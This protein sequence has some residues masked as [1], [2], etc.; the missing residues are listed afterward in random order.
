MSLTLGLEPRAVTLASGH[1][2]GVTVTVTNASD[3]VEQYEVLVLGLPEGVTAD[4]PAEALRLKPDASGTI[5]LTL[6]T[7]DE[8]LPPAGRAVAAVVVFSPH[9]PDV[10]RTSELAVTVEEVAGLTVSVQPEVITHRNPATT[11]ELTNTGNTPLDVTVSGRDPEDAVAVWVDRPAVR[12]AA[13]DRVQLAVQLSA[14]RPLSGQEVRRTVALRAQWD[15]QEATATVT[16]T[17]KPVVPGG[18]TRLLAAA[19]G[20]AVMAGT[21]LGSAFLVVRALASQ[22]PPGGETQTDETDAATEDTGGSTEGTEQPTDGSSGTASAT[23]TAAPPVV[24]EVD[25][26][27]PPTNANGTEL[28]VVTPGAFTGLAL[29]AVSDPDRD[30]CAVVTS[31]L[32]RILPVAGVSPGAVV[33]P[34]DQGDP[35]E[36]VCTDLPLRIELA[37][38][39]TEVVITF[40]GVGP[41]DAFEPLAYELRDPGGEI[42][43]T[44]VNPG[45]QGELTITSEDG[46]RELVFAGASGQPGTVPTLTAVRATAVTP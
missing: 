7:D 14:R 15:G 21:V 11:M 4:V 24:L 13:G 10:L 39:A 34:E 12:L 42:D 18:T 29:S 33:E 6:R 17:Q 41:E 28:Q 40:V 26:T 8:V 22:E 19:A 45:S 25:L 38:A 35:P 30:E 37:D 5:P 20:V 2:A 46:V 43:T 1:D 16:L 23:E 9:R 32:W 27:D 44:I 31:A 3:Q 36:A